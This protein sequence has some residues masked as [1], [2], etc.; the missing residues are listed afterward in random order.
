MKI[1]V[2]MYAYSKERRYLGIGKISYIDD[3]RKNFEIV[4]QTNKEEWLANKE[5]VIASY[6]I[7]DLIEVGDYVNGYKITYI[8]EKEEPYYPKRLLHFEEPQD[9]VIKV[10][11]NEDIKSIVTKEQFEREAYKI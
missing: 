5:D 10:F 8:Q 1:E 9:Y 6:N 4:I 7:I 2:G 11:D 3:I